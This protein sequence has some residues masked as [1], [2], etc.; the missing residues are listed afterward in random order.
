MPKYS[1]FCRACD[2]AYDVRLSSEEKESF[3][4][5]CPKCGSG[6]EKQEL[7]GIAGDGGGGGGCC[8]GGGRGCCG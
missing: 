1:Y 8:G 7:F 3:V 5:R 6:E 2:E 4:P